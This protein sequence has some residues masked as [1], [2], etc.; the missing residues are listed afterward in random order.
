MHE[1]TATIQNRAGIHCRPSALI[2]KSVEDYEGDIRVF[3]ERG[4]AD[5]RSIFGLMALAGM[6][7]ETVTIQVTGP[8]EEETCRKLADLFAFEFDFPPRE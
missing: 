8:D 6:Q 2:I 7:G 4:E 5:L 3:N 1:R